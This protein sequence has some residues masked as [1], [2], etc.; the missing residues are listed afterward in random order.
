MVIA[1]RINVSEGLDTQEI[2]G[3][4][5]SLGPDLQLVLVVAQFLWLCR[6]PKVST[7]SLSIFLKYLHII[8]LVALYPVGVLSLDPSG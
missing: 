4:S 1:N 8:N 2:V 3:G 7:R 5:W 6:V